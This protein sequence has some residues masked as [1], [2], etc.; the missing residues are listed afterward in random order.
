MSFV[1]GDQIVAHLVGDF[2]LQSD[3]MAVNKKERILP[4]LAHVLS[5]AVPFIFLA[6]SLLAMLVIIGS[7]FVID[8]W[9]LPQ[10]AIWA[11]NWLLSP[12]SERK[13]WESCSF[14]G[15][16]PDRQVWLTMWI[17]IIVDNTF[18]IIINALALKWL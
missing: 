8:H 2:F 7:H 13:T 11:K 3:F 18:H 6:P 17:M 5:Y 15:M 16:S 1:T 4:C 12:P 10:R 9:D 14:T